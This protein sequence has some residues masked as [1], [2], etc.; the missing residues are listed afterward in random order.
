MTTPSHSSHTATPLQEPPSKAWQPPCPSCPPPCR[1]RRQPAGSAKPRQG[2][3]PSQHRASMRSQ[4]PC[5]ACE[6]LWLQPCR[7]G[8]A[9]CHGARCQ[10][11][12]SFQLLQQPSCPSMAAAQ[13]WSLG[14]ARDHPPQYPPQ[15]PTIIAGPPRPP[16]PPPPEPQ[17]QVQPA[18]PRSR[19]SSPQTLDPRLLATRLP[20][21]PTTPQPQ[22]PISGGA[23]QQLRTRPH[24][25]VAP[26][27]AC[28]L[29]GLPCCSRC[30]CERWCMWEAAGG[31][32]H[33]FSASVA[34]MLTGCLMAPAGHCA[35][36][37]LLDD[38]VM[39]RGR[40]SSRFL[41]MRHH[42]LCILQC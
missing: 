18:E 14:R 5:G 10:Q 13:G 11:R 20:S 2:W 17:P 33:A 12:A 27:R 35:G 19:S 24:D 25:Q 15:C 16:P 8:W 39:S 38:V 21:R 9:S 26:L 28:L 22:P 40:P 4:T 42:S 3:Q 7:A 30:S 23:A 41:R 32:S 34:C 6:S 1:L 36:M 29:A 37:R 31:S